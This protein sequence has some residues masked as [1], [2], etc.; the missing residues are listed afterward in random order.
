[1]PRCLKES[2]EGG[3]GEQCG[4]GRGGDG[5]QRTGLGSLFPDP[6]LS[7]EQ[8]LRS[9]LH[10]WDKFAFQ[11]SS[12]NE[13][14]KIN[15]KQYY[16][17]ALSLLLLLPLALYCCIGGGTKTLL[18]LILCKKEKVLTNSE[19]KIETWGKQ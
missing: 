1:L 12:E 8:R 3:A 19:K 4:G 5:E 7:R 9:F 16:M 2:F 10:L 14:F 18:L 13:V 17:L 6:G 15:I 11:L